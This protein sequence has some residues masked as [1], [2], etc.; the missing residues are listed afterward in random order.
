M[1]ASRKFPT[2]PQP[3]LDTPSVNYYALSLA[4]SVERSPMTT[5][6]R[7]SIHL[8]I[9]QE[10]GL[11]S[12]FCEPYHSWEKGTIENLNGMIRWFF[13]KRTDFATIPDEDICRLETWL[14]LRPRK[15]LQFKS[16]ADTLKTWGWCIRT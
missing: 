5:V 9:N 13:P 7:M 1:S 4:I 16:P 6:Q 15:I 14:N 8:I 2:E 10:L 11:Q 3:L 12:Y